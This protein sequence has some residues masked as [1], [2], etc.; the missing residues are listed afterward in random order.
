MAAVAGHGGVTIRSLQINRLYSRRRE[1]QEKSHTHTRALAANDCVR[2]C[3]ASPRVRQF[4]LSWAAPTASPGGSGAGLPLSAWCQDGG[5]RW[6]VV[7]PELLPRR[8]DVRRPRGIT[9]CF[10]VTRTARGELAHDISL[11][12]VNRLVQ[13]AWAACALGW[14][15]AHN[16]VRSPLGRKNGQHAKASVTVWLLFSE[17]PCLLSFV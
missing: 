10:A 12:F 1:G 9:V 17:R 11:E 4:G 15:G 2:L 13:A 16:V 7:D 5:A 14:V 6:A 3:I 8:G